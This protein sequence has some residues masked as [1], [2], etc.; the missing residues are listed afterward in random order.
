M[1]GSSRKRTLSA[2][3]DTWP[4]QRIRTESLSNPIALPSAEPAT[5]WPLFREATPIPPP[6]AA[7]TWPHRHICTE[8]LSNPMALPSTEPAA[9]WPL[10]REPTLT[11]P[12]DANTR[13]PPRALTIVQRILS[14]GLR[15]FEIAKWQEEIRNLPIVRASLEATVKGPTA[16]ALAKFLVKA[17]NCLAQKAPV[18]EADH[19]LGVVATIPSI[20]SLLQD[21][22]RFRL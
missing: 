18:A 4:H 7:D 11:P 9:R 20:Y 5:R 17:L 19:E 3:A 16:C 12:P 14:Q 2:V 6:D 1:P 21:H 13:P 22:V 8:S 10:F 15:E